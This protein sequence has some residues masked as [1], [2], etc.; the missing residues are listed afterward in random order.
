M[1]NTTVRARKRE[2]GGG[3]G[4]GQA[5]AS[6]WQAEAVLKFCGAAQVAVYAAPC[7]R[8]VWWVAARAFI[9]HVTSRY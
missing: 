5:A 2:G 6:R 7:W 4:G 9:V 3:G 8:T 1:D